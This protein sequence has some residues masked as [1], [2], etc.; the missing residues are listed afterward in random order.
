MYLVFIIFLISILTT[1]V[2]EGKMPPVPNLNEFLKKIEQIES[3]GGKNTEH[4]VVEEG[5]QA[6]DQ[7]IGRYGLMPNTIRELVNRRR[8]EGS[9][10]GQLED[11]SRMP[12][13]EMKHYLEQ[14]PQLEDEL[15]KQ[16]ANIV[17]RKQM[18]DEDRSAYAWTMGHNLQ[19][20]DIT[21]DKLNESPYVQKFRKLKGM[22]GNE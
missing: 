21:D 13:S 5:I 9:T 3:S 15:A 7:A 10:D 6:G 18:G 8:I 16:M 20:D 4:P 2:S 12:S 1:K 22:L 14:S 11:L 19:P 17:T